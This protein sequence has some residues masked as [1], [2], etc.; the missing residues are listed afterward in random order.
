MVGG[1]NDRP[2]YLLHSLWSLARE[3]ETNDIEG[4]WGGGG[5]VSGGSLEGSGKHSEKTRAHPA[6]WAGRRFS[7]R[8]RSRAILW[9]DKR[10]AE[11]HST[12]LR[13]LLPQSAND[14]SLSRALVS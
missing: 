5:N 2:L 12:M 9:N 3:S 6:F 13:Y 8:Q 1:D 10:R 14:T 7:C 11:P 4:L